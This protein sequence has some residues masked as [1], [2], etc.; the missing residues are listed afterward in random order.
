M[1]VAEKKREKAMSRP[2]PFVTEIKR[3]LFI[4]GFILGMNPLPS[5]S[6]WVS[7]HLVERPGLFH[8]LLA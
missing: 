3:N 8:S 2:F 6:I 4:S 5:Y 7:H 1:D